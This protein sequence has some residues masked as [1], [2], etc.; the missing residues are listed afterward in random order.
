MNNKSNKF[1]NLKKLFPTLLSQSKSKRKIAESEEAAGRDAQEYDSDGNR[2]IYSGGYDDAKGSLDKQFNLKRIVNIKSNKPDSSR[3]KSNLQSGI[4]FDSLHARDLVTETNFD[5]CKNLSDGNFSEK[6][7]PEKSTSSSSSTL[8]SETD[9]DKNFKRKNDTPSKFVRKGSFNETSLRSG[10]S[11]LPTEKLNVYHGD[12]TFKSGR[13][14]APIIYQRKELEVKEHVSPVNYRR[15]KLLSPK[16]IRPLQSSN[17]GGFIENIKTQ[18]E[19]TYKESSNTFVPVSSVEITVALSPQPTHFKKKVNNQSPLSNVTTIH[20]PIVLNPISSKYKE[21]LPPN[22]IDNVQSSPIYDNMSQL[23]VACLE[24]DSV[25]KSKEIPNVKIRATS[26]PISSNASRS[27][28]EWQTPVTLAGNRN[29][30]FGTL[31]KLRNLQNV[32][33]FYWQQIKKIKQKQDNELLKQ[34]MSANNLAQM[35]LKNLPTLPNRSQP[36]FD[37]LRCRSVSPAFARASEYN[38]VS[39]QQLTPTNINIYRTNR[40][41]NKYVLQPSNPNF[42]RGSQYRNTIGSTDTISLNRN[43]KQE[44][45]ANSET[46]FGTLG[47]KTGTQYQNA[48]LVDPI[49]SKNC[50]RPPIFKR[51]SLSGDGI[52]NASLKEKRVS[53]SKLDKVEP[54]AE[55]PVDMEM[56]FPSSLMEEPQIVSRPQ[57]Q[58]PPENVYGEIRKPFNPYGY[59]QTGLP[60]SDPSKCVVQPNRSLNVGGKIPMHRYGYPT[61]SA[62][63][64]R[65]SVRPY[66]LQTSEDANVGRSGV[67]SESES[68]SEAGEV[69]RIMLG[70]SADS[71]RMSSGGGEGGGRSRVARRDDPRRHTLGG[72]L[73]RSA[74][75]HMDQ[76]APLSR[77]YP[78]PSSTML[79]DDDP[80]IMSEVETAS[81]GFRRGGKQRSSLPVVRT[82]SKTLERPLGLVFLQYRSE[83]KRALLPNEITSIDTV[84]ALFVRSFPKQLTMEYLD[85][86]LVKIYIHDSSKD[87]FYEL[88]DLRSHLRDIRDRSVLRLFESADVSGG[89]FPGALGGVVGMAVSGHHGSGPPSWDQDQSYFSEPEFDSEYHHQHIH[90]SKVNAKP[91]AYYMGAGPP[92]TLPRGGSLIRAYSPAGVPP[93][94]AD[95]IKSLPGGAGAPPKPVRAYGSTSSVL[96]GGSERCFPFSQPVDAM[97]ASDQ[98]YSLPADRIHNDGYMSSP[99]RGSRGAYEEPYYTQY[100][101]PSRGGMT[102]VIDEE[103]GDSSMLD[104]QYSLYSMKIPTGPRPAVRGPTYEGSRLN[105]HSEDIQQRIRVEH[106]ERQLANLTGLVQKAL[107]A[108]GTAQSP[109]DFLPV[110]PHFRTPSQDKSVS[111]EKSVSFSDEPPDM[112]SP[113]QHSPQ[114]TADTKPTKPAIKSSTLPRM[115][116]QDRDRL[117]PVPPPKPKTLVGIQGGSGIAGG[118]QMLMMQS[119]DYYTQLKILRKKCDEFRMDM[120]NLRR[121]SLA[122]THTMREMICDTFAKFRTATSYGG[123]FSFYEDS[124]ARDEEIYKQEMLKLELDLSDLESTVEQLRGNVIN[125]KTR[126]NMLDV[127]KM[128]LVLS[129]S[130]KTVADLKVRF[131][132]LHEG[133]KNMLSNQ[134][135]KV[136]RQEKFLKEE[137]ER[138]EMALRRCKKLTGTLVTLKRLASVQEQRLPCE[139][140]RISPGPSGILVDDQHPHDSNPSVHSKVKLALSNSNKKKMI[141][142]K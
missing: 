139:G 31:Q 34:T 62:A 125:R 38:V 110:G 10:P 36:R 84:K 48:R 138:L 40:S 80:G 94:P 97:R 3:L 83:T 117:K 68:G 85:S 30:N 88:E 13:M 134:M 137:P 6:N 119:M 15:K 50:E 70:S 43:S 53:F 124:L 75:G 118:H 89:A 11:S 100:V 52:L 33:A 67:G 55:C 20:Y 74:Q 63:R 18:K 51:G 102:P 22:I 77:G 122:Q 126:V 21:N 131:P 47:M 103:T 79:F 135:E 109:R 105:A 104:D 72:D 2:C 133:I 32:E 115:S 108:P 129:K 132:M 76:E 12:S 39:S 42:V 59:I 35:E 69:R 7:N 140:G 128:A 91:P 81:T 9:Q 121:M 23:S 130:S 4:N 26:T 17:E 123:D 90:K 93:I 92:S 120:R 65:T 46:K 82:P 56:F 19:V 71:N 112:N 29:S 8:V 127:E 107:Q 64:V 16:A 27:K 25:N 73:L 37:Q 111:F 1:N 106:M 136:V 58:Q 66:G 86:P 5:I 116:S 57:Q 142:L 60:R 28:A 98:L 141:N 44:Y 54:E 114:H 87:M 45:S 49:R 78:P 96:R 99:E 61:A 113:K 95:R 101:G 14:S 24:D 41:V